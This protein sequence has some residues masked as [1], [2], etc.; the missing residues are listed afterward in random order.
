MPVAPQL[1]QPEPDAVSGMKAYREVCGKHWKCELATA[2]RT[3]HYMRI[4]SCKEQAALQR[5]RNNH[6]PEFQHLTDADL[7]A[8]S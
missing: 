5:Y 1:T 7:D 3:G 6:L 8:W 4:L 2:W